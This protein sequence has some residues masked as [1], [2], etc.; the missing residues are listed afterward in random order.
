MPVHYEWDVETLE[1]DCDDIF[2]HHHSDTLQPIVH[3]LREPRTRLVLV[4]DVGNDVDGLTD[5]S[6]AYVINGRLPAH[7]SYDCDGNEVGAKVPKRFTV[8]MEKTT[9]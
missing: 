1:D 4:R 5:R 6:W 7:F 3:L 8:E 9:W 2:D